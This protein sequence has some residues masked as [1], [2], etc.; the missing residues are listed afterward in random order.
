MEIRFCNKIIR[1]RFP[2]EWTTGIV[3]NCESRDMR[4]LAVSLR[5]GLLLGGGQKH[6][7]SPFENAVRLSCSACRV[8]HSIQ[9]AMSAEALRQ[10]K[11]A[12]LGLKG[13][14][15]AK[16]SSL[17]KLHFLV[18]LLPQ[19]CLIIPATV[20]WHHVLYRPFSPIVKDIG[21]FLPLL[22]SN[23]FP[24]LLIPRPQ[25]SRCGL[26]GSCV[27]ILHREHVCRARRCDF[28][29]DWVV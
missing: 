21:R 1:Q 3:Q 16:L 28:G 2:R 11:V 25:I 9:R 29:S 6:S 13:V 14:A 8:R 24:R 20:I 27:K 12:A 22:N 23:L 4:S 26:H 17:E 15:P 10:R 5:L 7:R 19:L 18:V